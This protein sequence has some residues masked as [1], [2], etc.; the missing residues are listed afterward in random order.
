M[1]CKECGKEINDKA[2]M[3]PHCGC[4][5]GANAKNNQTS[6]EKSSKSRFMYIILIFL[7]GCFGINNFY[8]GRTKR[9][10]TELILSCTLIGL[11]VSIPMAIYDLFAI[12]TDNEG[13][14]LA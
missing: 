9:G 8:I 5:T 12:T 1:F 4:A 6:S 2:V 10:L 14:R 3:C 11:L 7:F 13:K